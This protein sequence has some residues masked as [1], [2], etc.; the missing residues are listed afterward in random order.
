MQS[1]KTLP[2]AVAV[3][4]V[5]VP[6]WLMFL[7]GLKI[8]VLTPPWLQRL[9]FEIQRSA[10]NALLLSFPLAVRGSGSAV[11]RTSRGTL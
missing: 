7:S 9:T 11:K 2:L 1:P 6:P 4:R 10:L 8:Q 3:L 5:S